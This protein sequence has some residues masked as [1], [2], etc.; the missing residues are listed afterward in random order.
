[1]DDRGKLRATI[2]AMVDEL[3]YTVYM[4]RKYEVYRRGEVV[5]PFTPA[6]ISEHAGYVKWYAD[7]L[8]TL[9][10]AISNSVDIKKIDE[11]TLPSNHNVIA[12]ELRRSYKSENKALYRV[13][14]LR[15]ELATARKWARCW[16]QQARFSKWLNLVFGRVR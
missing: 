16:K 13:R 8:L 9:S 1:M 5:L 12:E 3:N 4:L 15:A 14:K 6:Q 2:V 7:W 10:P 11:V